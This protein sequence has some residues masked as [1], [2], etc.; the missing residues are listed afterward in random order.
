MTDK[1]PTRVVYWGHSDK[2]GWAERVEKII[3]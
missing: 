3:D 2:R 1:K